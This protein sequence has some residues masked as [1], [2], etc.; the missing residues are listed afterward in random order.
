VDDVEAHYNQ[1]LAA[2]AKII[3]KPETA[4]YGGDY[5]ID[6]GYECEDPEGHHWW[7]YQR[8]RDP[9]PK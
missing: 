9:L 2:G 1:A 7:F 8:L 6:R 4:D 5:W 3:K